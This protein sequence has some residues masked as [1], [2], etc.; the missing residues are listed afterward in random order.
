MRTLCPYC[1]SVNTCDSEQS[2]MQIL[3][4]QCS[5]AF[6]ADP[7][8]EDEAEGFKACPYC[9]ERV[10]AGARKCRWCQS[11]LTAQPEKKCGT[12]PVEAASPVEKGAEVEERELERF[13]PSCKRL[14][15]PMLATLLVILASIPFLQKLHIGMYVVLAILLFC[16]V[17]F[18][19]LLFDILTTS[20][21]LTNQRLRAVSGLFTHYEVDIRL[22]DI[23]GVWLKQDLW[24]KLLGYGDISIGTSATSGMEIAI[25]DV[26]NPHAVLDLFHDLSKGQGEDSDGK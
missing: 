14:A 26:N 7:V 20:Y 18:S 2:G 17:W 16:L 4:S 9:H 3:C 24:E 5:K 22:T 15:A 10:R 1:K 21:T 12:S 19:V 11:M 8:P 23:R 25:R 13:R 6:F